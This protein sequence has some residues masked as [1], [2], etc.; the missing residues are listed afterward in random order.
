MTASALSRPLNVTT[1]SRVVASRPTIRPWIVQATQMTPAASARPW[2]VRH[3]P[4]L[5]V[6]T[7]PSS[8]TREVEPPS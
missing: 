8:V 2:G 1:G 7:L 3:L 5:L 6:V 4:M